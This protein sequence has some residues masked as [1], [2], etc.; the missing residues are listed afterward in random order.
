[1]TT[2][3]RTSPR[4]G[5]GRVPIEDG[6]AQ[7]TASQTARVAG[8]AYLF[9]VLGGIIYWLLVGTRLASAGSAGAT[10]GAVLAQE[11]LFRAGVA[12][13]ILMS[14]NVVV[15]AA[16]H[17]A[18]LERVGRGLSSL[19]FGLVLVDALLAAAMALAAFTALQ[20][21]KGGASLAVRGP[22]PLQELVGR[23]LD[24]RIAGH[25]VGSVF[26]D[27]GMMLFLWLLLRSGMIPR[28]LAGF[29]LLAYSAILLAALANI[30]APGSP[31]T[32]MTLKSAGEAAWVVPSILFEVTAGLWLLVRGVADRAPGPAARTAIEA[33]GEAFSG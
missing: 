32:M 33:R 14:V 3:V 5:R 8:L 27:L 25:T 31:P 21:L 2:N 22:G 12:C 13:E 9:L 23:Y 10:A 15:L 18:L 19:A 11:Q 7:A 29:G 16:A 28:W 17:R 26:L 4:G 20:V 1:M 30:L 24:V 6:A